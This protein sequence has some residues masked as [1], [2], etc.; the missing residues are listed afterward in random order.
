[1]RRGARHKHALITKSTAQTVATV[2]SPKSSSRP[3]AQA[4]PSAPPIWIAPYTWAATRPRRS[5][6]ADAPSKRGIARNCINDEIV[7]IAPNPLAFVTRTSARATHAFV[8]MLAISPRERLVELRSQP[9]DNAAT[10]PATIAPVR[11]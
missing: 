10:T 6:C 3:L 11:M 2:R 7:T 8:T 5:M 4:G 9:A 1:M